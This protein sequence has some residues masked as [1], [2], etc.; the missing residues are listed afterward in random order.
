MVMCEPTSLLMT[1]WV[2]RPLRMLFL[3]SSQLMPWAET[4]FSRSSMLVEIVLDA[5]L[6]ETL[7]HV[8]LDADAHIFAALHE[9]GLVDQIAQGVFLAVFDGSLQL[10]RSAAILAILLGVFGG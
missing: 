2:S 8:G 4:A 3:K 1:R 9:Q 7:D 5:N 6:I 10:F